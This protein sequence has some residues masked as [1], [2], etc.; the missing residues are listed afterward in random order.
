[1]ARRSYAG[2][3]SGVTLTA[4]A[5][6]IATSLSVNTLVGVPNGSSGPFAICVGKGTV[7]EEKMLVSSASAGVMS[8]SQ[9]GYDGTSPRPHSAGEEVILVITAIDADEANA[10]VNSSTGVHGL[11]V[12]VPVVGTSS[13]QTLTNKSMDGDNN[14]FTDL[15]LSSMPAMVAAL[16]AEET[17]RLAGDADRYTKAESDSL[18]TTPTES[19]G[20]TDAA[21]ASH[22][23]DADP[24]T[25]YLSGNGS[26]SNRL[27]LADFPRVTNNWVW[28][29]DI[30]AVTPTDGAP[31]QVLAAATVTP[32]NMDVAGT[33]LFMVT[34]VVKGFTTG[35]STGEI[36]RFQVRLTLSGAP[37]LA[38]V[39]PTTGDGPAINRRMGDNIATPA[40]GVHVAGYFRCS[41][42][43]ANITVSAIMTK[44]SGINATSSGA[45]GHLTVVQL[46]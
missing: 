27:R 6:D 11:G 22:E 24:H 23:G 18:F 21:M 39:M 46:T 20:Y 40:D 43:N 25:Q 4:S 31:D 26:A 7:N 38:W 45:D 29:D 13:S 35:G 17:A 32:E 19:E 15:P 28:A 41:D 42:S 1:M 3:A 36:A 34:C 30:T 16:D 33:R 8:I 5:T 37:S 44:I 2:G 12:G 10:H 14:T 9:R